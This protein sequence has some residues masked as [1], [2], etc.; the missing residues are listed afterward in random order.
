MAAIVKL[1]GSVEYDYQHDIDNPN[2]PLPGPIWLHSLLGDD[3]FRT[4]D[5]VLFSRRLPL[6]D[7]DLNHVAVLEKLKYLCLGDTHVTD[8]GVKKPALSR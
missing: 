2:A 8:A 3:V 1:G 7:A 5:N 6:K 4:A